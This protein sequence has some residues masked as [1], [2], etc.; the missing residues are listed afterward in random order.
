MSTAQLA[1]TMLVGL[2]GG[3]LAGHA[4]WVV[5]RRDSWKTGGV[6]L[7]TMAGADSLAREHVLGLGLGVVFAL[8][9]YFRHDSLPVVLVIVAFVLQLTL[10]LLIDLWHR[11]VY[12]A[13]VLVGVVSGVALNALAGT[14][15]VLSCVIAALL[16]VLVFVLLYL[17]GRLLLRVEAI[18]TGD[19]MLAGMI[20]AMT[21]LDK[22]FPALLWGM[23]L[24]G[25]FA[26]ALL[27][28][29]RGRRGQYMP[30]GPGLCLGAML[31][32]A[33]S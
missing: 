1:I 16:G 18:A 11:L 17:L 25:V 30:Y 5:P 2:L 24:A 29:G 27:A 21:G 7:L 13:L 32:L 26:V 19:I 14:E 33:L 15:G 22:L 31:V 28:S 23:I 3:F 8:A 12:P 4:A 9:A 10:A 6:G 20:G